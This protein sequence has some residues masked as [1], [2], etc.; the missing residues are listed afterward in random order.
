MCYSSGMVIQNQIKRT[1]TQPNHIEYIQRLVEDNPEWSRSKLSLEVCEHFG[2][3]DPGGRPQSSGCL[4]SLRDLESA[5]HITLAESRTTPGKKSP[6]RPSAAI[7]PAE[8]VP[9]EAGEVDGLSLIL[10]RSQEEMQTWNELM[11][12][13]HPRGA[14]PLVG[15]QLRYLVSS[16]HGWLGGFGFASAALHLNDRDRWIGWDTQ[17]RRENLHSVVCMSRFLIRPE[18]RCRNLASKLLGMCMK[19][20]GGDFE[21]LYGYRPV[22]IESFADEQYSGASYRAANWRWVGKTCGRGRPFGR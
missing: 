7:P 10:V 22:L 3:S 15:R 17:I 5:G 18:I 13:G 9:A 4:K 6:R 2:F 16:D 19:C 12:S 8:N 20:M 21:D 11:I 14:G 1:L